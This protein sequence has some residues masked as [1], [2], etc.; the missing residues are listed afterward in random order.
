MARFFMR[1]M[2]VL[3]LA[4]LAG[5]G[6][7]LTISNDALYTLHEWIDYARFHR[8]DAMIEETG[9]K[10]HVDPMLIKAVVWRESAFAEDM[11]GR[12]G[13]RGLMQVTEGAAKDW[14]RSQKNETFQPN[15]LF[16][17]KTNIDV[18][19]WYLKQSLD[20]YSA[21]DDPVTFALAEYNAG[22]QRVN[23][24]IGEDNLGPV[25]ADDLQKNISFPGTRSYVQSI[26]SRYS[27]YKRRARM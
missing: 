26:Q 13:E 18:G 9:R 7:T 15:D 17:P 10:Y 8:Y 4:L 23:R 24:W 12:N 21:K 20:H 22:R 1:L 16:D 5:V 19:T 25:T 11:V 2:V 6:I 3:L 27:F 14:A